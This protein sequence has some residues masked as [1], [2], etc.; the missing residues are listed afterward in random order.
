MPKAYFISGLG[1]DCTVFTRLR[2]PQQYEPVYIEWKPLDKG[3]TLS[4]YSEKM[5][6]EVTISEGDVL[7]GLSF[8]GLLALE[9]ARK[10]EAKLVI[11]ISSFRE[12]SDLRPL[13][14]MLIRLRA[15]QLIPPFAYRYLKTMAQ[16][17]LGG[18]SKKGKR[19]LKQMMDNTDL[20]FTKWAL[21][22]ISQ[23]SFNKP[24]GTQIINILG[25]KDPLVSPWKIDRDFLIGEGGHFMVFEKAAQLNE[26]L[27]KNL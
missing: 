26:V 7:I 27:Q 4:S 5:G 15:Y 16:V 24:E 17:T 1:A 25:D 23:Y 21:R 22:Q 8:G 6:A 13:P 18:S 20:H 19:L 2:L 12:L 9:I 3:E 11:L 10:K 14:K